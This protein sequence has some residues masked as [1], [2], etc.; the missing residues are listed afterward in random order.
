MLTAVGVI[1][2]RYGSSRLPGKPLVELQGKPLLYHVYHRSSQAKTLDEVWIATDDQRILEAAKGFGANVIMTSGDHR[3]GTD[4]IA[5]AVAEISAQ[6]VVNIQGD[7]PLMDPFAIDDAVRLL[8]EDAEAEM[9]TLK[10][11]IHELEDLWNPNVVKVVTDERGYAMYFSRT[12]IPYPRLKEMPGNSLPEV[13][14]KHPRQL[15]YF[16]RHIGLYAYRREFLMRYTKWEPSPLEVLE[17]LEQL[18]AME[19]GAK[20]KVGTTP[21]A[22]MGIDTPED[23]ERIRRMVDRNPRLMEA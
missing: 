5:E 7:E 10:T 22:P 17:D 23:L 6:F 19:H 12:P 4:R 15:K 9:S 2:A 20:I 8:Q 14:Q 3:S 13:L 16:F 11:P 21:A 1:P 18:R